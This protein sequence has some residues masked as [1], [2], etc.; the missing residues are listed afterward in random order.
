[1]IHRRIRRRQRPRQA[2]LEGIVV[3]LNEFHASFGQ[4]H[5]VCTVFWNVIYLG[6]LHYMHYRYIQH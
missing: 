1:M 3:G 6:L 2:P 4:L 5:V